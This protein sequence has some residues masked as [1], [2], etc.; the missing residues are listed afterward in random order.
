MCILRPEIYSWRL[1]GAVMSALACKTGRG[2]F[3][4]ISEKIVCHNVQ[5]VLPI[6]TSLSGEVE[7][8]CRR[9]TCDIT[10]LVYLCSLIQIGPK[11]RSQVFLK[12]G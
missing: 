4:S 5:P 3:E 1:G 11:L 6:G 2:G 10:V 8:R 7:R 12:G 9:N